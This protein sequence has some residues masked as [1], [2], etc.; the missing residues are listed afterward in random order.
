MSN[1][2]AQVNMSCIQVPPVLIAGG[3]LPRLVS[4]LCYSDYESEL[5]SLEEKM[6][7]F[8]EKADMEKGQDEK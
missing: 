5:K 3:E 1:P 6:P 4:E 8:K 7:A 2:I